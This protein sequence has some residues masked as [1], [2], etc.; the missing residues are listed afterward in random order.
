M[1]KVSGDGIFSNKG[2]TAD[3][4]VSSSII[5]LLSRRARMRVEGKTKSRCLYPVSSSLSCFSSFSFSSP[6]LF[7]LFLRLC[8]R[9]RGTSSPA[10]EPRDPSHL[11]LLSLD[12]LLFIEIIGFYLKHIL[13]LIQSFILNIKPAT[14]T[15]GSWKLE[16]NH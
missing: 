16:Y 2:V 9:A 1:T 4:R 12:C 6:F 5:I 10:H 11:P 13:K 3:E 15:A 8:N 7:L 14:I